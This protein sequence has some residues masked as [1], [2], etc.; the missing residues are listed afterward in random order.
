MIHLTSPNPNVELHLS[1]GRILSGPRGTQVGEFLRA[2]KDDFSAPIVAAILNNEIH[3]LT[4]PIER[5]SDCAPVTMDRADGARIYRRSLIFL[6]EIA[7]AELFPKG[8]LTIDHSVSSG[9]FYCQVTEREA[10][11][12]K[13]L[14]ALKTHMEKIVAEDQAFERKQIPIQEAIQY[15]EKLGY[16][17]KVRLFSHRQKD[18]LTLYSLNGRM[19][20]LH[21]YMVPSTGY[22]RWFDLNC[23]DGGFTLQFPR[24][25]APTHLE[26]MGDYPKLLNTFRQYGDWLTRLAIDNVGALNDAIVAGR[27]DELIMVSEALHEQHVADIAQQIAQKNSRIIL[28]AGPS[29]SGKTTTSRRLAIQLLARGISPYPL[30]LDNYFIDRSKTPLDEEG[31]PDFEALEALDLNR[32]AQDIEKLLRGEK[33]Q[34]PRYNFKSGLSE[35]GDEIQLKDGQPLILEGIHGMNPRL[36]PDRWSGAAFR[37]YVSALTQLNLDRHNRVSTTDTRLI[38]RMVRDARER[39]YSATQTISRWESVRRG[40]KRHIFPYQENADVMFNSALVYELAALK[41]LAEPLLRQVQH[42]SPE[43]IEARR[44]LAFLEWFL[45]LDVNLI[46]ANSI[47]R[48]FLGSSSLKDFKIWRG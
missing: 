40:E 47:V 42:R 6:L 17:D 12:Q 15:F 37:V 48:E 23:I 36:I 41:P 20:Y 16:S 21:G 44:L 35:M 32:L 22:L 5:E 26:P 27:A 45:P 25:H 18:Y 34:L 19:D 43:Y 38:R 13:E 9:G 7:F 11:T 33:V 4:Y 14:D 28:I 24:R 8:K 10:L 39:G 2:V 31:K 1:D 46:P 29:S 30:E 3:E